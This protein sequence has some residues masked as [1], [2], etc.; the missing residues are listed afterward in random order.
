MMSGS[1]QEKQWRSQRLE[2][3]GMLTGSVA[4]DFNNL[5]TMINAHAEAALEEIP[6]QSEAAKDL[7][8]ILRI[9]G[10][11]GA[12]TSQLLSFLRRTPTVDKPLNLNHLIEQSASMYKRLL[13]DKIKLTLRLGSEV[14]PILADVARMEQVLVNLLVNA[15]EAM[16]KGGLV[17]IA[18]TVI[19]A[20][21]CL[22]VADNGPGMD[23]ETRARV[24]EPFFT[25]REAGGGTGIGLST[26]ATIVNEGGGRIHLQTSLGKGATFT[27]YWPVLQSL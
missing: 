17:L 20:S 26:V 11:A 1:K 18:T 21:L 16:P 19:D 14:K 24:F 27:I 7:N 25:T 23:E 9:T 6:A 5:L 15:K 4:H 3:A 12:L 8:S 13:G 2:V 22:E 10:K